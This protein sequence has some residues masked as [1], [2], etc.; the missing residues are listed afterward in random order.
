ME[1]KT[2]ISL[3]GDFSNLLTLIFVTLKLTRFINWS[4]WLV[5]SP[6]LVSFVILISLLGCIFILKVIASK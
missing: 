4:W 1:N 5:L 3:G 2:T 6:L